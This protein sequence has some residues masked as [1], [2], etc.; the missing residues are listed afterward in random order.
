MAVNAAEGTPPP[1]SSAP[2][3]GGSARVGEGEDDPLLLE[4][5]SRVDAESGRKKY[6]LVGAKL[7]QP[8]RDVIAWAGCR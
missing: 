6:V 5:G 1:A 3:P 2:P 7:R 8:V 4:D